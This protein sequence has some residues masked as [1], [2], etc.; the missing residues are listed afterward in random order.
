MPKTDPS[1]HASPGAQLPHLGNQLI[2]LGRKFRDLCEL[3]EKVLAERFEG[4]GK[5]EKFEFSDGDRIFVMGFGP[6]RY[7]LKVS[8]A[9]APAD[10]DFQTNWSGGSRYVECSMTLK[11]QPGAPIGNRQRA[12]SE[13]GYVT[14]EAGFR[15]NREF[16]MTVI[17]LLQE[18]LATVQEKVL[19]EKKSVAAG[20]NPTLAQCLGSI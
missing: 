15:R 3:L 14:A 11:N 6:V 5:L 4:R 9:G 18:L 12:D 16:A 8:K 1:I 7:T 20:A 10:L 17:P 19:S 2:T 13:W